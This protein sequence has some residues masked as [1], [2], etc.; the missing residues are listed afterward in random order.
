M[1][2]W[3]IKIENKTLYY[4]IIFVLLSFKSINPI[5]IV[6]YIHISVTDRAFDF[7]YYDIYFYILKAQP[8]KIL[9]K[10]FCLEITKE[11]CWTE[12]HNFFTDLIFLWQLLWDFQFFLVSVMKLS[13]N[14]VT[15]HY[16]QYS[17]I[18]SWYLFYSSKF[19][20]FQSV[21]DSQNN[22]DIITMIT[23]WLG[24]ISLHFLKDDAIFIQSFIVIQHV[25]KKKNRGMPSQIRGWKQHYS[26]LSL[27]S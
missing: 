4:K 11:V 19:V 23:T 14:H 1:Y 22:D 8:V 24:P 13:K 26:A 5:S 17:C 12:V 3:R 21:S 9:L 15:S 10:S 25:V 18:F 2:I 6:R 7:K 20:I 27:N 16:G